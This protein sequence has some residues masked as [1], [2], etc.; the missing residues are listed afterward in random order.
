MKRNPHS[1]T[2][3]FVRAILLVKGVHFYGFHSSY[4]PFLKIVI[5]DPAFVTRAVTVLQ[6]G[7]VM[8]T[9]FNVY[10]SHLSYVLQFMCDFGLYGCGWIDL[11]EVWQRGQEDEEQD[12]DRNENGQTFQKFNLS[13]HF[14]QTR[15]ALE[16]DAAAHQIMNRH[17]LVARDLHHNL[18][19]PAPPLPPEPLVI[20]VRELWEDERRRRLARGLSPSP[21]IPIDP[22]ESSRG[23]GGEWVAEARWWDEIRKRIEKERESNVEVVASGSGWEKEVMTTFESVQ[24]LWERERKR[25]RHRPREPSQA[26]VGRNQAG[27][28]DDSEHEVG[29]ESEREGEYTEGHCAWDQPNI[30]AQDVEVDVDEIMLSSQEM[31]RMVEIEEQEWAKLMGENKEF[32]NEDGHG[33]G[34]EG[35]F[36]DEEDVQLSEDGPPSDLQAENEDVLPFHNSDQTKMKRLVVYVVL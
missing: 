13:P 16:V 4:S 2:S 7:N 32:E 9:R 21:E 33:D 30:R 18:T 10:E 23:P 6:F 11:G 8:R 25:R 5:I 29:H 28:L 3:K 26:E 27:E 19:I 1:P 34:D 24:A 36:D 35:Y 20:S 22:S 17:Q 15:M 31:S 14:R 12:F